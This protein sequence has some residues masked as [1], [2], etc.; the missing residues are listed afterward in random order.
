MIPDR[1]GEKEIF[2]DF[3]PISSILSNK[4]GGFSPSSSDDE[5]GT[6]VVVEVSEHGST[7]Q[8]PVI[9]ASEHARST[10]NPIRR[11]VDAMSANPNPEKELIRLNIGD[12][13][14][15]GVLPTHASVRQA[16]AAALLS[17]QYNGYGPAVGFP[18]VRQAVADHVN[19]T[20]RYPAPVTAED[21][22]LTSGCSHALQLAIEALANPGQNILV[23]RPGFPLYTTLMRPLGVQERHYDLCPERGWEVDLQAMERLIDAKTAAIVVNNPNNPCG[24]VYTR[25]HLRDILRVAERYRVPVIADEIYGNMV[26]GG[27]KFHPIASLGARVPVLT[28]DGISK[29]YLVPGWRLG[30]VII[31]DVDGAFTEIRQAIRQLSQKIVGPCALIQGAV[32][33]MLRNTPKDFFD[34]TT[35]I[36]CAN[37]DI[38]LKTLSSIPGLHPIRSYGAMYIMIALDMSAFPAFRT[39]LAFTQALLSEESVYTLPG[40]AFNYAGALRIV[41]TNPKESIAD[42][43]RRIRSFCLRHHNNPPTPT[44]S[45]DEDDV[46]SAS[47]SSMNVDI[48]ENDL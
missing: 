19:Q 25:Q 31:H 43:C 14:V 9:E 22:V 48:D 35:S 28:C 37:A 26:Y 5:D 47:A 46:M 16:V 29:R 30:W 42:A 33:A 10:I 32:P 38:V 23:P 6:I 4:D 27:A 41:L 2:A 34:H 17:G 15:S 12:P 24:A 3:A 39:D 7:S 18:E 45:S 44:A 1:S 11:I 20:H 8:W 40:S 36:L 13:S 21:V